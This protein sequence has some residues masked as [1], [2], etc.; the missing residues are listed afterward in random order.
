MP[1]QVPDPGSLDRL[2]DIITPPAAPWWPPATG[3]YVL[4]ALVLVGLAVATWWAT[5]WWIRNAYRR[6]GLTELARL[7]LAANAPATFESLVE[8]V[9]RVALAAFP[10][11]QVASL[12]GHDWLKFLDETA[13]MKDFINGPG[14]M[15][16]TGYEPG[17][18]R[19]SPEL[20]GAVRRWIRSHRVA[21]A[22]HKKGVWNPSQSG[23]PLAASQSQGSR[24]LFCAKS[25]AEDER[26]RNSTG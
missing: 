14:A 19:A 15:L 24:H 9:K 11:E 18:H 17:I 23:Q 3:W 10:R 12:S 6:G 8:L 13:G 26:P 21:E 16:I 20:F 4:G 2:H 7:E 5:A 1:P 25:A 22:S